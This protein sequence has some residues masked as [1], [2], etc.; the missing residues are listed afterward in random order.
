MKLASFV[1]W[2]IDF[3]VEPLGIEVMLKSDEYRVATALDLIC[4]VTVKEKGYWGETY[5]SDSKSTGAKKGDPKESYKEVKQLAIVDYKSGKNFYDKN[6][7]QLLESKLIFEENFPDIKVGGI[8]NFGANDWKGSTPTYK[9][10]NQ[11][12]ENKNIDFLK[13]IFKNVLDR[14]KVEF[15]HKILPKRKRQFVGSADFSN[16]TME[17]VVK[18]ETL[19]ETAQ[20]YWLEANTVVDHFK[21]FIDENKIETGKNLR[22]C[23]NPKDAA[24]L[25]DLAL[26]VGLKYNNRQKFIQRMVEKFNS[27]K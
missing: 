20:R 21:V 27:Y 9:F 19:E 7:L 5:K 11:E 4:Y 23:L 2:C 25:K 15:E 16:L 10:Y 26:K 18:Y 8:Y 17:N 13:A 1:Q 24:E 22:T 6:V 3:K 12:R 14:G